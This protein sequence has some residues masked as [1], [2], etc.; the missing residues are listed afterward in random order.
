MRAL[1]GHNAIDEHRQHRQR[2]RQATLRFLRVQLAQRLFDGKIAF[3]LS[4]MVSSCF[5]CQPQK[6]NQVTASWLKTVR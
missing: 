4:L 1:T 5:G 2:L 3:R 6:L